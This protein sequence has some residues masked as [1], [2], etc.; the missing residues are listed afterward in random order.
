MSLEDGRKRFKRAAGILAEE[1]D[2]IK[3]RLLIAYA[4]Q[5]S[6]IDANEDLPHDLIDD[7]CTLRNALSDAEMAYGSGERA[8][9]KIRAMDEEEASSW[10]SKI[11]A[12]CLELCGQ[13]SK[14]LVG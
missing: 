12:T 13:E 7:F 4:S 6:L 14:R 1:K 3:D 2:R 10:A 5:L 8:A 9:E 11:F